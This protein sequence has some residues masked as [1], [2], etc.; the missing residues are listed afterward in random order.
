[1]NAGR[2]LIMPKGNYDAS[3]QY[4][5]LDLVYYNGA[6]WIAK[7]NVSGIVPSESDYWQK[8]AESGV[9]I[10]K[11]INYINCEAGRA[12]GYTLGEPAISGY[13]KIGAVHNL[14]VDEDTVIGN[15]TLYQKTDTD[16]EIY[17]DF[18]GKVK[19]VGTFFFT[20]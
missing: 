11:S 4:E 6:S 9:A 16:G 5:M 14:G 10:E 20:M 3:A 8:M 15:A 2:I 17:A 18:N 12:V 1:M 13:S 7:K 19:I